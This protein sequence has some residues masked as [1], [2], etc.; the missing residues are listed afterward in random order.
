[1][2]PA[3]FVLIIVAA[4]AAQTR[5]ASTA[6]WR[7]DVDALKAK[8]D[9]AGALARLEQVEQGAK[10][11]AALEDE[12]GFLL[13]VLNQRAGAM[14]RFRK[15]LAIDAKFAAA[16]YHLG[17]AL[18]LEG[19]REEALPA[20]EQAARLGPKVFDYRYRYGAALVEL[21]KTAAVTECKAATSLRTGSA[22]AWNQLGLALQH[23]GDRKAAAAA[24][25]KAVDLEPANTDFR[26]NYGLM[27]L[28]TGSPDKAIAQFQALLARDPGN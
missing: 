7:A 23:Q 14:D 8:G 11:S 18:W 26:N 5:T 3:L 2:R 25:A 19:N 12:M 17:V 21:G 20:L 6:G 28:E 10:P 4:G 9:A 13:A 1:M 22:A 24:Y 15:A 27:L 16:H